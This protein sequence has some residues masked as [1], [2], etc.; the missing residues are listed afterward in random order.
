MKLLFKGGKIV[1]V[2]SGALNEA[3]VLVENG[4]IA[5]IGSYPEKDAD[6]VVDCSGK[7]LSPGFIDGHIHI[8]STM[9]SPAEFAKA[10][11]ARGTTAVVADPHE[12]ANV[13][14][15][16]GIDYMLESSRGLPVSVYIALPSCVPA[17][18]Y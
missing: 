13:L 2:F 15:E 8:E 17:T 16:V 9:L 11:I 1:D 10:V 12:I 14:G 4:V 5:G 7:Y 3:D 18:P 6:E